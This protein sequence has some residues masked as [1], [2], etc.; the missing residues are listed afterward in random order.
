[1]RSCD[2][3][4]RGSSR[5][6]PA[7]DDLLRFR[8]FLKVKTGLPMRAEL[9]ANY[10]I[11][12]KGSIKHLG[13][14]EKARK[15]IYRGLIR[16]QPKLG[17]RTFA[18]IID[19]QRLWQRHPDDD[20]MKVA[21]TYMMQRLESLTRRPQDQVLVIHDEGEAEIIRQI[22]RRFRRYGTAG[23][24]FGGGYQ[25]P[26][27]VGLLDDPVSRNSQHSYFL[28]LADLNAYAAFRR[29]YPPPLKTVQ[30]VPQLLWDE[31]G[32]AR[33][34]PANGRHGGPSIAI[35]HWPRA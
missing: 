28:Q 8:R 15:F 26:P 10:L 24:L 6:A 4:P 17:V 11:H 29:A 13:L 7:F 22:A 30:I 5:W 18:I 1:M 16:L 25:I 33:F 14:S 23:S 19:K 27:F 2:D 32:V 34:R 20:P 21:W 35:V 3:V 9:K 12:A 31:L